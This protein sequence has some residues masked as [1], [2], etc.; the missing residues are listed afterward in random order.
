M[1]GADRRNTRRHGFQELVRRREVVVEC[2]VLEQ[3]ANDVGGRDPL[4][5][6]GG[7]HRGQDVN[8]PLVLGAGGGRPELG[9]EGAVPHHREDAARDPSD[10]GHQLLDA[11]PDREAALVEDDACLRIEAE[12]LVE[13]PRL[14]R[15]RREPV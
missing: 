12:E 11:T 7:W 2:V 13:P 10:G 3:D 9:L 4:E 15:R 1:V 6:L 5:Q 14:R 8:A